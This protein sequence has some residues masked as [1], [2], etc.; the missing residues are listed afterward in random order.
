MR[1]DGK[2][3]WCERWNNDLHVQVT[4]KQ[5]AGRGISLCCGCSPFSKGTDGKHRQGH[6]VTCILW[7]KSAIFSIF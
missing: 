2:R 4:H 1:K 6:T 5:K 3:G 7:R